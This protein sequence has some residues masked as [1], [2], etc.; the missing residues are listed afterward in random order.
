MSFAPSLSSTLQRLELSGETQHAL[1]Y[2]FAFGLCASLALA[3][4]LVDQ[5]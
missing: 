4:R 1:V 3:H 2:R 5:Q